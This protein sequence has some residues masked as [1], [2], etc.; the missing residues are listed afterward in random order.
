MSSRI[1]SSYPTDFSSVI[2]SDLGNE[3]FPEGLQTILG[4]GNPN[5][6]S[7][8][9]QQSG[10]SPD[11]PERSAAVYLPDDGS[12]PTGATITS[13]VLHV[14]HY[15]TNATGNMAIRA[16]IAG[17]GTSYS[18]TPVTDAQVTTDF[19]FTTKSNG[20]AWTRAA[21]FTER[22]GVDGQCPTVGGDSWNATEFWVTVNYIGATP[23]A[24]TG[25]ASD[26]SASTVTLNGIINPNGTTA[27][28]KFQYGLTSAYGAETAPVTGQVGSADIPAM[29]IAS[30]LVGT[31]TYHFRIVAYNSDVS[32]NGLDASFSTISADFPVFIL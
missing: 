29:S 3:D 2:H 26:I 27:S 1:F 32:T 19:T 13:V 16:Y 4:I 6:G 18:S 31:T 12:I 7:G 17:S 11:F 14:T 20:A 10:R 9:S 21:L 25:A 28:Y 22:Y 24:T 5:A 15:G 8:I 23:T 30:G